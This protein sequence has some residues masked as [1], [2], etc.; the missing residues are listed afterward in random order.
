VKE[1]LRKEL[2]KRNEVIK[3]AAEAL[4][5][6]EEAPKSRVV[7]CGPGQKLFSAL[8]AP[9]ALPAYLIDFAV[10]VLDVATLHPSVAA[11]VPKLD[12]AYCIQLNEAHAML[13]AWEMNEK[14][15][16]TGPTGSGKSS[17]VQYCC[18]LT[19]R[20]MVRVNMSGDMETHVLFGTLTVENGGTVWKDGPVTEGVLYGAVV[21]CDEWDVTPPEILF[22]MQWLLEEG[23]KL[24][25][26]E[27]PGESNDKMIEPHANFRMV[28]LGNTVGQGDETGRYSGTNVQNT[29]SIDRF[30]TTIVLGYLDAMHE[31]EVI[32]K[33]CKGLK[34]DLIKKMV[35]FAAQVRNACNT[36][37]IN[38][39]MS[40]RTLINWGR[41]I[42]VYG[43]PQSALSLAF[44][45]KL[46]DTDRK[47]V[48]EL[49]FK[50]FGRA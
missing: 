23:G 8:I 37:Q 25:L 9:Q 48:N 30:Q 14:V 35:S 18:A 27:K 28:C 47:V 12:P 16:I 6:V 2:M 10:T 46:R 13:M 40:P 39:T 43:D 3:A 32:A 17:L 5:V 34:K 15:L 11:F 38:L 7:E 1:A 44:L 50:V 45:N 36:S 4:P 20:P 24:F 21:C 19:N 33:Q 26:K 22:S 29:A 41:K 49:Y 42:L 31:E